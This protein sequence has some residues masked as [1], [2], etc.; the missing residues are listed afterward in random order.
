[1]FLT[2]PSKK[3]VTSVTTQLHNVLCGLNRT[4]VFTLE[5]ELAFRKQEF[6]P[7]LPLYLFCFVLAGR[8]P[9]VSLFSNFL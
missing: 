9:T 7:E 2:S 3:H 1:M 5:W 6:S 4:G 8:N